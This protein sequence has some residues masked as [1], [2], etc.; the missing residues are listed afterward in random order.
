MS[1]SY[2][3]N[4]NLTKIGMI[5]ENGKKNAGYGTVCDLQS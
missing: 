1:I 5:Y 2:I 4:F 3:G